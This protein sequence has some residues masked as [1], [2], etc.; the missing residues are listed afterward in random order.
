MQK[1]NESRYPYPMR[2]CVRFGALAAG[3]FLFLPGVA[4]SAQAP[5]STVRQKW[6]REGVVVG[7]AAGE[8][9][10]VKRPS[11]VRRRTYGHD[12]CA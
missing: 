11:Y 4:T 6:S 7:K 2:V 8:S 5:G 12:R 9:Y 1:S 3:A 10:G